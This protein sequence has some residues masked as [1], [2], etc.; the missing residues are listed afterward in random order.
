[1][2][3]HIRDACL[4]ADPLELF[5]AVHIGLPGLRVGDDVFSGAAVVGPQECLIEVDIH[6]FNL[7]SPAAAGPAFAGPQSY[8]PLLEINVLQPRRFILLILAAV[9]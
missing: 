1:M 3:V 5:T 8:L 6:A 2:P 9:E 7:C 4:P